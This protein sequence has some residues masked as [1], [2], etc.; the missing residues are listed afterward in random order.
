MPS[1]PLEKLIPSS[2]DT[3]FHAQRLPI[4]LGPSNN[5][6]LRPR[7]TFGV[8][9]GGAGSS[10][11]SRSQDLSGASG[12][13]KWLLLARVQGRPWHHP[14]PQNACGGAAP[15]RRSGPRTGWWPEEHGPRLV[16]LVYHPK[17]VA[18]RKDTLQLPRRL[19]LHYVYLRQFR[20][21]VA[22]DS[23]YMLTCFFSTALVLWWKRGFECKP[24]HLGAPLSFLRLIGF[25]DSRLVR[26]SG[27]KLVTLARPCE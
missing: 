24:G 18:A 4:D 7:T 13:E 11:E 20:G 1:K 8:S 16:Y 5:Q 25:W 14:K 2:L 17:R 12:W 9:N 21:H 3:F 22:K 10:I 19:C 15:S 27:M 26:L 23:V 6:V